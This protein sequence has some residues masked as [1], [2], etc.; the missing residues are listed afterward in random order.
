[1][2]IKWNESPLQKVGVNSGPPRN[3]N[4]AYRRVS[5]RR[6]TYRRVSHKRASHRGHPISHRPPH[7]R[8][9]HRRASHIA[10]RRASPIS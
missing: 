10:Y 5:H 1:M 8:A 2:N 7:R 6:L 4:L 3:F 9:S